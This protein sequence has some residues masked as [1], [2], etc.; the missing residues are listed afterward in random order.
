MATPSKKEG[1]D[2]PKNV[3]DKIALRDP[4]ATAEP[5]GKLQDY[6]GQTFRLK[7]LDGS[8]KEVEWVVKPTGPRSFELTVPSSHELGYPEAWEG[9]SIMTQRV[10]CKSGSCGCDGSQCGCQGQDC[11]SNCNSNKGRL[12]LLSRVEVEQQINTELLQQL[13]S[14]LG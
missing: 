9:I 3:S 10:T 4:R 5:V 13:R 1:P 14:K 7:G 8:G 11:G 6:V 2:L 12:Q